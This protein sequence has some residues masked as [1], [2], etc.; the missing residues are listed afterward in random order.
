MLTNKVRII[1]AIIIIINADK[2]F[3]PPIERHQV[4][5][6]S[7]VIAA[8]RNSADHGGEFIDKSLLLLKRRTDYRK[9]LVTEQCTLLVHS[10][11]CFIVDDNNH[12]YIIRMPMLSDIV[13]ITRNKFRFE[14]CG[15]NNC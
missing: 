12:I 3:G 5:N 9:S 7:S 4:T 15:Y 1:H 10:D 13:N 11:R 8:I 2:D 14:N 6:I